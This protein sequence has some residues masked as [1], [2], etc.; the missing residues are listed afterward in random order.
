M[1][2]SGNVMST[3]CKPLSGQSITSLN[4]SWE[5]LKPGH[6][7]HGCTKTNTLDPECDKKPESEQYLY[8][9]FDVLHCHLYLIQM[10]SWDFRLRCYNDQE[11]VEL[12]WLGSND[13][14]A[15]DTL[16]VFTRR[17][18]RFGISRI[19][20]CKPTKGE[21]KTTMQKMTWNPD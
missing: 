17:G 19:F 16:T 21:P 8:H 10:T 9:R 7:R 2:Q 14:G 11:R 15:S 6:E 12:S 20:F 5:L 18:D 4:E 13:K 1:A 3:V